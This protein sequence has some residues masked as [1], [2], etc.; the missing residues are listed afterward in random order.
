MPEPLVALES[1]VL[2]HG[3]PY[4]LNLE[5]AEALE[6]AVAQEGAIPKTIALVE[7]KVRVGLSRE[8]KEALARGG[9]EKASLWNL[10]AL[11][12]QGKSAGTTVAATLH[13]A[14]RHG[15]RV[16]AT[17]GIGGV[18]P[19]PYDESADLLALARTPLLVVASGPKAILDLRATLERLETLGVVLVGYRTDRL[20]AFFSPSSPFP[21]PARVETP[22]EAARVYLEARELGLGAVLLVNPVSQGLPFERVAAWVEEASHQAA[23]EG[24]YGKALTPYL[25]RRLSELSRGETDRVNGLLL[26]E[27]ARLAAQVALALSGLE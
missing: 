1:A 17:G 11:L 18:H 26:R 2:T 3:L 14:H 25:L 10:P 9:A 21:V 22:L 7:G 16:F 4:P 8:E 19:E 27:N 15:I 12:A 24:I 6:A 20:P 5:T 23:R 13:L